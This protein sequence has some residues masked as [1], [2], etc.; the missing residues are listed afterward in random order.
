MIEKKATSLRLFFD[1]SQDN[2]GFKG[3]VFKN[4]V[5]TL[6][7]MLLKPVDYMLQ[8]ISCTLFF[9]VTRH[10]VVFFT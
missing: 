1:L 10:S 8:T 3:R 6:K 7:K 5:C 2:C 9:S 4:G